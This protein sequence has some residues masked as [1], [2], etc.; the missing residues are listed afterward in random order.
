M[1]KPLLSPLSCSRASAQ[2]EGAAPGP[3][4][5]P[6]NQGFHPGPGRADLDV[7]FLRGS[8]HRGTQSP[9]WARQGGKDVPF[10]RGSSHRG[11]RSSALAQRDAL[12]E[13]Q[14]IEG[15]Q[16]S[17]FISA[18]L[19]PSSTA[20]GRVFPSFVAAPSP[21]LNLHLKPSFLLQQ[22]AESSPSALL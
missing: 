17:P 11:T 12:I 7:P 19:L 16:S 2:L 5:D 6:K 3:R 10:P 18:S 9:S 4:R 20:G 1:G 14:W 21:S 13:A 8:P 22:A 15:D